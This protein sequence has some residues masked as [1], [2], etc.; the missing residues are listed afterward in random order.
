MW[1]AL[2][3]FEVPALRYDDETK[4]LTMIGTV[5]STIGVAYVGDAVFDA[6]SVTW[7]A[8]VSAGQ[9]YPDKNGSSG[10]AKASKVTQY[11]KTFGTNGNFVAFL[12]YE[13]PNL[14]KVITKYYTFT[15]TDARP[16]PVDP[17]AIKAETDTIV[18]ET[19]GRNVTK[20][21]INYIGT[22]NKSITN[23]DEFLA[24]AAPY[25][26]INGPDHNQQYFNPA[27]GTGWRQDKSG[28]YEV[29]V[30]YVEDGETFTNYCTVQITATTDAP[31]AAIAD[32]AI[33][34][35][36]NGNT[37]D[38]VCVAYIGAEDLYIDNWNDYVA[39]GQK[40]AAINGEDGCV[41]T[42]S[43]A[44]GETWNAEESGYYCLFIRYIT[45]DGVAKSF[46]VN[47]NQ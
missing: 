37:I 4:T 47:V 20:V 28:Y 38:K 24:A 13:D 40:Y 30:R 36:A 31:E 46:Y 5:E 12:K 35:T 34:V 1:A 7:D 10:Y 44:V 41:M 26:R 33:R 11:S 19:N 14:H 29:Y 22:E 25:S 15:V 3:A 43:P 32:S 6:N 9:A 27:D 2:K 16:E 39:A 23:W 8:F 21:T 42:S 18:L 17:P 45:E